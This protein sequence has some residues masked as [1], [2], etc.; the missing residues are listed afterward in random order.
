MFGSFSYYLFSAFFGLS[1]GW[2]VVMGLNQG[3]S[4]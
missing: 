4:R 3:L 2:A 1:I